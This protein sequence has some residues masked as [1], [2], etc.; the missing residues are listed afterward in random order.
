MVRN[1]SNQTH[2]HSF[3]IPPRKRQ[4]PNEPLRDPHPIH[5][6]WDAGTLITA[7]PCKSSVCRKFSLLPEISS[8]RYVIGGDT[9]I[10]AGAGDTP[11]W[12]LLEVDIPI[13]EHPHEADWAGSRI[14]RITESS[15]LFS[16]DHHLH[17]TVQC[18]YDD[19]TKQE[20]VHRRLQFSLPLQLVHSSNTLVPS[21]GCYTPDAG[22]PTETQMETPPAHSLPAYSQLFYPNGERKIDYST[23]LPLYEPPSPSPT[24]SPQKSN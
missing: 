9:C 24:S 6:S 12:Y 16:V 21:V 2:I 14:R 19:P 15:P 17:V 1:T 11:E 22:S 13:A 20:L 3:P 5:T 7:Q 18:E 23:P 8:G 10:F 4:P